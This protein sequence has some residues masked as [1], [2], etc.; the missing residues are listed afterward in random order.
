[1]KQISEKAPYTRFTRSHSATPTATGCGDLRGV[2]NKLDYI[3]E[4]GVDY[5]WLT[6]FFVSPQNDNGY[7][8]EDYY[9][10]DPRYGTMADV[11][12]LI[13]GGRQTRDPPDVRHGVQPRTPPR[14]EWFQKAM[15]RRS[16]LQRFLLFPQR[17]S[18]RECL[19]QTGRASSAEAP[20]NTWRSSMNTISTSLT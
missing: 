9:N 15:A 19:P 20:G 16:L 2:I 12:E 11:E 14:H 13:G 6:P 18:G 5:I 7:D 3:K 17:E 8:V 10:I 1:M 4:L